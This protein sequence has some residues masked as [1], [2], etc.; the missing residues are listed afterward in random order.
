MEAAAAAFG[1]F[2]RQTGSKPSGHTISWAPDFNA[3]NEG[4][5]LF[6]ELFDSDPD[7]ADRL[8]EAIATMPE[9]GSSF[10]GFQLVRELGRGGFGRV[11]LA[12][13]GELSDR[14]VALKISTHV[15]GEALT[16]AQLQHTNIV[17]IYS[18]H[19]TNVLQGLC[20]PYLGATTL[21]H[22]LRVIALR[23][24]LPLSGKEIVST[25]HDQVHSTQ[26]PASSQESKQLPAVTLPSVPVGAPATNDP[27]LEL[28]KL[29]GLT[30]VQAVLWIGSRLA[31]GLAHAHERGIIHQDLKPDN[32]LLADDGQ[33]MLLDFNL[34]HD[35]KLR[36][37]S[38][39]AAIGG[40]LLY[41]APEQLRSFGTKT[42]AVDPR[43]D[44]YSLGVVLYEMLACR[45][46]F[47]IPTG[48]ATEVIE[49][50]IADRLQ[51]PP[52]L[53]TWNRSVSPATE[54]I[55]QRCL[56]PDIERRYQ[57]ARHLQ[58][59]LE[60][61]LDSLPLRHV[62]EPSLA[63][64]FHKWVR[65]HP[66]LTSM[67]S[68]AVFSMALVTAL[69]LVILWRGQRLAQL[70]ALSKWNAFREEAVD[71]QTLLFG[72]NTDT[73]ERNQGLEQAQQA[74]KRYRLPDDDG[75]Q[76]RPAVVNLPAEERK[77]LQ[78]SVGDLLFVMARSTTLATEANRDSSPNL[79]DALEWNQ[80]AEHCYPEDQ[81]PAALWRQRGEL[82]AR[83]GKGDAD[84]F[85]RRADE[86]TLDYAR[87][88]F[89]L[90]YLNWT[91]GNHRS[92][93]KL[94]EKATFKDP[95]NY[96]T[97]FV[98]G[99]CHDSLQQNG[100]AVACYSTCIAL[101]PDAHWAWYNRG[102]AYYRLQ[103]QPKAEADLTQVIALQPELT[104]AYINRAQAREALGKFADALADLDTAL[105]RGSNRTEIYFMRARTRHLL[106]DQAGARKDFEE[107]LRRPPEDVVSWV[108]R[109]L[110]R[111]ATSNPQAP[112]AKQV[113]LAA[114]A[115]FDQALRLN[116]RW[117]SALQNKAHVLGEWL[118]DDAGAV[119][120][121]DRAVELYPDNV[122]PRSGRGVHR[123]RLG[124]RDLALDDA[125]EALLLDTH[126]P[127]LYQVACIYALT[128]AKNPPDRLRAFELL[129]AALK[130]GFGHEFLDEDTDLDPIRK[131]PEFQKIARAAKD[132]IPTDQGRPN[133]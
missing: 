64:R 4:A 98:R 51:G 42:V 58:E 52:S 3:A 77:Q 74:L 25:I 56:E 107:G 17:P 66:R 11:F 110:A 28:K 125:R 67:S 116:P 76:H 9:A 82:L 95:Q 103:E 124:T 112:Q 5:R 37:S 27:P 93:L 108:S 59:D 39:A 49:K 133:P 50:L 87:D 121:L 106:H 33:P 128:S 60:R 126:P 53:Q 90:G 54:A 13:Q 131:T 85:K 19:R 83:L 109:G 79:A 62:T 21:G 65:R 43:C 20:M 88:Y 69:I 94:L 84:I 122:L 63:E 132:L 36:S 115:D 12:K 71:A 29:G 99:Q 119:K 40:T 7:A 35:T 57:N 6:E 123:A 31:D 48:P 91:E 8:A 68:V 86:Q 101:K 24:S 97:W 73:Q 114:L 46:P 22:V 111:L 129:A 61:Q 100:E 78:G 70:E 96:L 55:I 117:F 72:R 75:W 45:S 1:D 113:A 105:Q 47:A 10:A 14:L 16:L 118:H 81:I 89:L 38:A 18:A 34:A 127:T 80:S 44:I 104:D 32:V 26:V 2:R 41:M 102:L 23:G 130:G 92:A 120:V 30:Y 15:F